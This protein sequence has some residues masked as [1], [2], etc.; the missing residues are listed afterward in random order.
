MAASAFTESAQAGTAPTAV[1]QDNLIRDRV[2]YLLQTSE[3][4]RQH[5]DRRG[6]RRVPF[7]YPIYI[8]PIGK[9]DSPDLGET[10]VVLG[11]HLAE[12]GLDFYHQEPLPYRKVIVSFDQG[13][14]RWLA[15]EMVLTWCRF[16]RHGWYDTGGKF[17]QIVASPLGG[18]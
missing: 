7:P 5:D 12:R 6:D 15:F 1:A 14:G 18:T 2:E 16:S 17:T 4:Q 10:F 9:N 8:T 13:A 3:M 11:K